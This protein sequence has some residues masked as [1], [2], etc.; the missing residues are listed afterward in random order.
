MITRDTYKLDGGMDLDD[1]D[2]E[3]G[4]DLESESSETIGGFLIDIL[5]E[6][7]DDD[8]LGKDIPYGR[9]IFTI[10]SIKDRR[11]EGVTMKILPAEDPDHE[12]TEEK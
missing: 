3:L 4:I 2:E 8:D 5:G 11:I 12:E 7:P 1:V 6:I 10:D 9:Y